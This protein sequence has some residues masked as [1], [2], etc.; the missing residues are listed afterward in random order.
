MLSEA[1][2]RPFR[3]WPVRGGYP[4]LRSFLASPWAGIFRAFGPEQMTLNLVPF[5]SDY[6]SGFLALIGG[7]L[8]VEGFGACNRP[9]VRDTWGSKIH[10]GHGPFH[11]KAFAC[12]E[13]AMGVKKRMV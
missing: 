10:A 3:A 9:L 13:D 5:G 1:L 11:W 6:D 2:L 7:V 8:E 12:R 4:G